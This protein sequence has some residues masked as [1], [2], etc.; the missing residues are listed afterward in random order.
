M[1]LS[2]GGKTRKTV[3]TALFAVLIT[4]CTWLCIP[5]AVPFTMQTFAVFL[6]SLLLDGKRG[7]VSV[8]VYLAL[9]AVGLPVFSGFQGGVG[10]LFGPTGGYL[11]GFLL[12]P[13]CFLLRK[14]FGDFT[15][16]R[17]AFLGLGLVLCYAFGTAWY[18]FVYTR[19]GMASVGAA[20]LQCVAPYVLP[21]AAKLALALALARRLEKIKIGS[22]R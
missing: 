4:V 2:G 15:A 1:R 20:V 21:D 5:A 22:I 16:V 10:V 3:Y 12:I 18:V 11:F 13:L 19:G 8:F 14:P 9:G 17:A 7:A 6:A